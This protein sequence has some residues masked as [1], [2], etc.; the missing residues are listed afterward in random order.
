VISIFVA[1]GN[2]KKVEEVKME[3]YSCFG[4]K[5]VLRGCMLLDR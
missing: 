5:D 2:T 1:R 4:E 3:D